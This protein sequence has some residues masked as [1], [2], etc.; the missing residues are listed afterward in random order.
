MEPALLLASLVLYL[1]GTLAGGANVARPGEGTR[2]ATAIALALGFV[3][4]A[5]A[6]G[7][8]SIPLG[9]LVIATFADQVA[10]FTCLVA[11]V[12]LLVQSRYR[13]AVLGALVGPI[14]FVGALVALV[15]H[16]GARD[17]PPELRSPWLPVHVTLAFLGNAAFAFA[18]LVSLIYLWQ[19]RKLKAHSVD[20]RM[21]GLPSLETLDQANFR[22]LTWGFVLLTLS[23]LSGVLWAELSFGRLWAWEPRTIWSTIVWM[24]YA[25]LVHGRITVGWGGRRA[26]AL[27]IVGFGV[28]FVS[29]IGVNALAPGRHA[30]SFG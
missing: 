27:T 17:L 24:I 19:E 13:L 11:G 1:V 6:I 23:I 26:A 9:T 20:F 8:R 21:R 7:V 5:A 16:G 22:C 18:C 25:V 4:Q 14:G 30:E 2:Q 28:L 15:D 29:F 10:L 3:V 12:Y